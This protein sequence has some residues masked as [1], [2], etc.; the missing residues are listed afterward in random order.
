MAHPGDEPKGP[1]SIPEEM[2]SLPPAADPGG[3]SLDD[4][5]DDPVDDRPSWQVEEEPA[6]PAPSMGEASGYVVHVGDEPEPAA[7]ASEDEDEDRVGGALNTMAMVAAAAVLG[8][9]GAIGVAFFMLDTEVDVPVEET[10]PEQ[11][12]GVKVRRGLDGQRPNPQDALDKKLAEL[13][14]QKAEAGDAGEEAGE[15]AA[16]VDTPEGAG[17][18]EPVAEEGAEPSEAPKGDEPAQDLKLNDALK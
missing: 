1:F 4:L 15:D 8:L 3:A 5:Y 10:K 12:G 7:A 9:F 17:A 2:Q 16:A 18:A 14:Q 6:R 13:E 11:V